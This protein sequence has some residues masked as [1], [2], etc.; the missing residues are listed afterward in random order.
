MK[1][2]IYKEFY[3]S[4]KLRIIGI[5]IYILLM[6]LCILVKLS[7]LYG[8][9]GHLAE[10]T[11]SSV[12]SVTFYIMTYGGAAVLFA[13][14]F[15]CQIAADEKSGFRRYGQTL[16]VTEYKMVGAVYLLNLI[17]LAAVTVICWVIMLIACLMFGRDIEPKL[18]LYI[19]GIGCFVYMFFH[20]NMAVNYNFRRAKT[21]KMIFTVI[22]MTLYFGAAFGLVHWMD[23]YCIKMT[24]FSIYDEEAEDV[25]NQ[26][27]TMFYKDEVMGKIT[28]LGDNLWWLIPAVLLTLTALWYF[29]SVRGLKRRG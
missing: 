13:C 18:L 9:I 23:S 8:N 20:A 4:R 3:L 2:L 1:G 5:A 6:L 14:Q 11:V 15:T 22:F 28:W 12:E 29:L 16:P 10:S 26:V 24:G 25:T 17:C 27:M 21:A 19:F 7:A